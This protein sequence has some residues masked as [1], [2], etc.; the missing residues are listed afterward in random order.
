[1]A[2]IGSISL[3]INGSLGYGLASLL[4]KP[5]KKNQELSH[6]DAILRVAPGTSYAVCI[7]KMAKSKEEVVEIANILMQECLDLLSMTGKEDLVTRE[8]SEEYV[9][10]WKEK[11]KK[12]I[13]YY[14]TTTISISV[15][16]PNL[17]VLDSDG[18][19]IPQL[20]IPPNYHHA[21][22]FYR[23]AQVSDDLFDSFRNMY[24]ALEALLSSKYPKKNKQKEIDWLI[25]ALND[26]ESVLHLQEIIPSG[27]TQFEDFFVENIY[28]QARLPLFHSKESENNYIPHTKYNRNTIETALSFLTKIV[29][30]MAETWYSCR[31]LGGWTNLK[32]I[33]ENYK[34]LFNDI[35][36]VLTDDPKFTLEDKSESPS[37]KEGNRF[38]AQYN[39]LYM[40]NYRPNIYGK[41][42][43][44]SL[45]KRRPV[46]A[47]FLLKE[48]KTL[49]GCLLE[50]SID[51][52][53]FDFFETFQFLK[54]NNASQPKYLFSR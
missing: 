15:G 11:D 19:I 36:F 9:V 45:N 29:I 5:P 41:I 54:G 12:I 8:T 52:E 27:P 53:G 3:D 21:F 30:K 32:L 16:N 7:L 49:L 17:Q 38:P 39:E 4:V 40:D 50:S 42:N 43:I 2:K 25:S 33:E 13:S 46:L 24:L 37:I 35:H 26:S 23:L 31:R 44:A 18:N 51:T 34:V 14:S 6:K 28:K 20:V 47:L 10:W 22:R 48:N 1:M